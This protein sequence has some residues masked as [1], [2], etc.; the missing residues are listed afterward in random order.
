[1]RNLVGFLL[2]LCSVGA[3]SG[4]GL[5]LGWGAVLLMAWAILGAVGVN[6]LAN[7]KR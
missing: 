5:L 1:M 4:A 6:I 7:R 3:A 2:I